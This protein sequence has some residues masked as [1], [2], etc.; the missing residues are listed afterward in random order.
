MERA[1]LRFDFQRSFFFKP[2]LTFSTISLNKTSLR[3]NRSRW[4][5]EVKGVP[6]N[7]AVVLFAEGNFWGRT[8]AAVS[9]STDPESF[10]GFGPFMPGFKTVPYN[11][12]PSLEKELEENPNVV[13]FM[14]EPIQVRLFYF[15]FG[16]RRK[17]ERK[18]E[19]NSDAS[20]RRSFQ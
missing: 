5:Y 16:R 13:A 14:V 6:K 17:R 12:I 2:K 19:S 11:D 10:G 8:L 20:R 9:S 1:S 4:G 3:T 18:E 15:F 7:Q